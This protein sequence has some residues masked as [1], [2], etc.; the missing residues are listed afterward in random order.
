MKKQNLHAKARQT[1][2]IVAVTIVSVQL[3]VGGMLDYVFPEWR[4]IGLKQGLANCQQA[5][6]TQPLIVVLGSSRFGGGVLP[7][8]VEKALH[9]NGVSAHVVNLCAPGGDFISAEYII[10]LLLQREIV[11]DCVLLEISPETLAKRNLWLNLHCL[12]QLTWFDGPRYSVDLIRSGHFLRF[13]ASRLNPIY[14]FRE[15]IRV[16]LEAHL[17]PDWRQEIARHLQGNVGLAFQNASEAA[18]QQFTK[19]EMLSKT[20]SGT[21][22]INRWLKHYEIGGTSKAAFD[23]VLHVC[24]QRGCKVILMGA[25]VTQSHR[26][27]YNADIERAY[28]KL[29]HASLSQYPDMQFVDARAVMEEQVFFDNHHLTQQGARLFS[30]YVATKLLPSV[31]S[32]SNKRAK[33]YT[34]CIM[35]NR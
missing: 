35:P 13:L 1:V 22:F 9:A 33:Q 30:D 11:P 14:T 26:Q 31:Q 5:D 20:Q 27:L 34:S 32:L 6:K 17:L 15:Q 8:D 16:H 29:I 24:H 19:A 10:Q 7:K 21:D 23:R 3:L 4:F 2:I 25:P 18:E 12:R 28:Q